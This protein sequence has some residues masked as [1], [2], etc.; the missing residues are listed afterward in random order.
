MTRQIVYGAAVSLDGY[1]AGPNEEV[2]WLRWTQDVADISQ[3]TFASADTVLMGRRTYEA[4]VRAGMRAFPD[5]R[6]VVFSRTLDPAEYPEV[7]I[8]ESDAAEFVR[9]LKEEPGRDM[10]LMGGGALARS[11]IVAGLVDTIGVNVQPIILGAGVPLLPETGTRVLLE[12]LAT[13][14]LAEG[15]VYS[16]YRVIG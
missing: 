8:V 9:R 13:R 5:A 14:A 1:I 15:C 12:L 7:E 16:L 10:I 11:L 6:N 2:D 4:G 3:Q